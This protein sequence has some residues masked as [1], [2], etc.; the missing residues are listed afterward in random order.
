MKRALTL[1]AM[2]SGVVLI[3][4]IAIQAAG[5]S[6]AH[7]L[8]MFFEGA[9]G[10]KTQFEYT[11]DRSMPLLFTALGVAIA[12]HA[13]LFNIGAQGQMII[14]GILAT[15][16]GYAAPMPP[17]LHIA[18]ILLAGAV[19]GAV[20]A[21]PAVAI[22]AWR[23]GHEV[24]TTIMFNYLA[25]YLSG[26][27]L[28]GPMQAV[29]KFAEPKTP[30]LLRTAWM[31]MLPGLDGIVSFGL[32][33][34]AVFAVLL[35]LWLSFTPGGYELRAVGANRDA[36][37][38]NGISS[39]RAML[40]AMCIGGALAGLGGAAIVT[41]VPERRLF[42]GFSAEYGFDGLAVAL[43]AGGHPLGILPA[44]A[45]FGGIDIGTRYLGTVTT[46]PR[47]ISQVVRGMVILCVAV[48]AWQRHKESK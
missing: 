47:D 16:V 26:Y 1:L 3:L 31:P 4:A 18:A 42:E 39:R 24:I 5:T 28:N 10:S 21:L 13:G 23:G 46:V 32:V 27:L 19:G 8:R 45:L 14:G 9:F 36:A 43:L 41:S 34:G 6:P 2:V 15:F 11:L 17:G 33:F 37:E 20:W 25:L 7:A 35:W 48:L 12:L 38:A 40:L 30:P 29:S 22:K 44:A